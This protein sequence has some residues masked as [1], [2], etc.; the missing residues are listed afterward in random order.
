M[1]ALTVQEV[2]D[3]GGNGYGNVCNSCFNIS[4]DLCAFIRNLNQTSQ[5]HLLKSGDCGT[6]SEWLLLKLKMVTS[7]SLLILHII[8][9]LITGEYKMPQQNELPN[10]DPAWDYA[11]I[12]EKLNETTNDAIALLNYIATIENANHDS[13]VLIIETLAVVGQKLNSINGLMKQQ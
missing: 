6:Q 3:K 12:Y 11:T 1:I 9:T 2:V 10:F 8:C 13:D 5:L 7:N 4:F